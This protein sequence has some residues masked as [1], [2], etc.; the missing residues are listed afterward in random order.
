MQ[1]ALGEEKTAVADEAK[2]LPVNFLVQQHRALDQ[3]AARHALVFGEQRQ[4]GAVEAVTVVQE[5]GFRLARPAIDVDARVQVDRKSS[6][7]L[8][9]VA[10]VER[11]D[12]AGEQFGFVFFQMRVLDA[13]EH[14]AGFA[15]FHRLGADKFHIA[16]GVGKNLIGPRDCTDLDRE[17]ISEAHAIV[18]AQ[19][20]QLAIDLDK[21]PAIGHLAIHPAFFKAENGAV[22]RVF[23]KDPRVAGFKKVGD[24]ALRK[25]PGVQLL[26]GGQYMLIGNLIESQFIS[27]GDWN[28]GSA[29]SLILAVIILIFMCLMKK[30][31]TQDD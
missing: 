13:V 23:V 4:N 22:G 2:F 8:P 1:A 6:A 5:K 30:M 11:L 18:I 3:L 31:D 24:A 7:P 12:A 14:A 9:P 17:Q 25:K 16:L 26:G 20:H 27:V 10:F 28:F 15:G 21:A 29:I 19:E